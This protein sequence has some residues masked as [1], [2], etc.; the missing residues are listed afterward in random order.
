MGFATYAV[1]PLSFFSNVSVIY[2]LMVS[3][4]PVL[5][6]LFPSFLIFS[7][8]GFATIASLSIFFGRIHYKSKIFQ[9]DNQV[10]TEQNPYIYKTP[11]GI[12]Q[13]LSIP[14]NILLLKSLRKLADERDQAYFDY[15][16]HSWEELR[17][18]KDVRDIIQ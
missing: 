11:P 18:G 14:T 15:L 12:N 13:H 2:Y 6:S 1:F 7:F 17:N 5:Q 4:I 10:N 9:K 3:H 16:I 8:F